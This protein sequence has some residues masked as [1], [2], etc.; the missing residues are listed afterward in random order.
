MEHD[1]SNHLVHRGHKRLWS[2]IITDGINQL[3]H[4]E[5]CASKDLIYDWCMPT[6]VV[7]FNVNNQ[8]P[9]L[10]NEIYQLVKGRRQISSQ[11]VEW[12][13]QKQVVSSVYVHDPKFCIELCKDHWNDRF[14]YSKCVSL[15][16]IK[17]SH[18]D[19][20]LFKLPPNKILTAS[21]SIAHKY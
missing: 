17:G 18:V 10:T 9:L 21:E 5:I 15:H 13:S 3:Y 19:L 11:T 1:C 7:S 16:L 20:V 12:P 4:F 14:H 6:E 2:Q 8:F